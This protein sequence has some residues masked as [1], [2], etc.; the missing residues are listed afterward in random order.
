MALN[1]LKQERFSFYLRRGLTLSNHVT[2]P[3]SDYVESASR[4][5]ADTVH[6]IMTRTDPPSMALTLVPTVGTSPL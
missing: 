2:T 4:L 3:P 1:S 6:A 5:A